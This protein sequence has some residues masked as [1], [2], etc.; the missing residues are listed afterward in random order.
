MTGRVVRIAPAGRDFRRPCGAGGASGASLVFPA[1]APL[2]S[3][4]ASHVSLLM[5]TYSEALAGHRSAIDALNVYP[6]PDGDTGTNMSLT[7][8][9]VVE[10]LPSDSDLR[11]T[12]Q[13]IYD[14]ALAAGR[15]NSGI[16]VSQFLRAM[17]GAW[18]EVSSVDAAKLAAS[19]REAAEAAYGAVARPVEG[20]ILTVGRDVAEA[21]VAAAERGAPLSTVVEEAIEAGR[22]SLERTP[23]LLEVLRTAGVVDAGGKGLLLLL[24]ALAHVVDGRPLPEP[25][26]VSAPLLGGDPHAGAGAEGDIADLR[27]EVM[28]LLDS[29]EDRIGAFR[30]RWGELGDSIVIVGGDGLW[31]CHI[32]TDDIGGSIEA[33]IEAGRPHRIEVTDLLDQ[34][35]HVDHVAAPV[36]TTSGV[37]AVA[38]GD[39]VR[40]IF[41]SLGVAEV[42]LGGQ[43]MNPSVAT[44]L[45]AVERVPSEQVLVLPNNKNIVLA[46]QQLAELTDKDVV[47][48]PTVS[49]PEGLSAMVEFDPEAPAAG[50]GEVMAALA[51]DVVTGEVTR[52]VRDAV[53]PAGPVAEGDFMGLT[54]D[55]V[56]CTAGELAEATCGLLALIVGDEHEILTLISGAEATEADTEAVSNWL[57]ENHPHIETEIH[58][59]GQPLY[60]YYLGVE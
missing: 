52:A 35:A 7:I 32:H 9:S 40:R 24:D 12:C 30:E 31:N 22:V 41:E 45:A 33:G 6:V 58:D 38:A 10:A 13:S 46:A 23:E 20:T 25:P 51:S 59:G 36:R 28:F 14:S 42:V 34:V 44:L 39:G 29:S 60:H 11:A 3:L 50:N 18:R 26:E 8:R 53:T 2:E 43:T 48:V 4:T 17:A 19:L 56:Q 5:R 27:Y 15:G 21:A 1:M 54:P 57:A 49:I 47:V 16:I 55:G 37:V